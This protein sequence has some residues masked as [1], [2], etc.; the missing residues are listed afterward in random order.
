MV[1]WADAVE[2]AYIKDI[3]QADI[4]EQLRDQLKKAISRLSTRR[5]YQ[6]E[7][8]PVPENDIEE[9]ISK[10][11]AHNEEELRTFI[12]FIKEYEARKQGK[13]TSGRSSSPSYPAC[14]ALG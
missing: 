9:T 1:A 3:T 7:D 11:V 10:T 13:L 6:R 8:E 5:F 14:G 2:V 4:R 12:L